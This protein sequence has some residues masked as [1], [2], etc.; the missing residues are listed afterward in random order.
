MLGR[1]PSCHS[2]SGAAVRG[3]YD[4]LK[5]WQTIAAALIALLA[6]LIAARPVWQ[7]LSVARAQTLQ[8]SYEQLLA[9]SLHLY[10]E[11]EAL[12]NLTSAIEIMLKSLT[13]LPELDSVRG[14]TANIVSS[15]QGPHNHLTEIVKTYKD[16][17]GI[18][19]GDVDVQRSRASMLD[20]ALRFC[21]ELKKLM[22]LLII[23]NCLSQAEVA[24][25]T[26]VLF[27]YN[28]VVISAATFLQQ[29]IDAETARIGPIIADLEAALL[30]EVGKLVR[31]R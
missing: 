26:T 12:Y 3:W 22:D 1:G 4:V 23:G 10:K 20:Q 30:T 8:R 2:F 28:Q 15:V 16:E 24:K 11:R 6:A 25:Y 31:R 21:N 13:A 18:A 14:I 7:Q 27:Q 5:D 19:W 29:A 17:F 9:R